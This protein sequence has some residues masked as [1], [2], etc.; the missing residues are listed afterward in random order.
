MVIGVPGIGGYVGASRSRGARVVARPGPD[1]A[2]IAIGRGQH[3]RALRAGKH[4]L[5]IE[6]ARRTPA[7]PRHVALV[8]LLQPMLKLGRAFRRR[9]A[10]EAAGIK[11]Q[12]PGLVSDGLL[13]AHVQP[14]V[15]DRNSCS[16][17]SATSRAE[18][19][20]LVIRMSACR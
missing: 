18:R 7:Q 5:W 4:K 3:H 8:S 17:W 6:A 20:S 15:A 12:F 2:G 16:T 11:T 10:G 13:Q 9:D 1:R 14:L 19:P